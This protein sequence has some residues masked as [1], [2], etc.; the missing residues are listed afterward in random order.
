MSGLEKQELVIRVQGMTEE[1]KR[2]IAKTL[3][4]EII[5]TELCVRFGNMKQMLNNISRA[6]KENSPADYQSK[7]DY[8]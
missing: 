3:P 4:D 8:K 2:L 5:L 1:E 7:Q 6:V